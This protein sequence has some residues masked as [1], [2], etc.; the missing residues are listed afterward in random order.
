MQDR[1]QLRPS[2]AMLLKP[3]DDVRAVLEVVRHGGQF[4]ALLRKIFVQ[5]FSGKFHGP[6]HRRHPAKELAID[7]IGDAAQKDA[8]GG[9]A[10]ERITDARP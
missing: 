8:E 9:S 1:L 10:H 5:Q 4:P 6:W 7:E 2:A 3:G